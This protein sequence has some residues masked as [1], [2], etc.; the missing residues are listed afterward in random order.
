M[1]NET[2]RQLQLTQLEMLKEI[3]RVCEKHNITYFLTD[4]TL[5][6]AARHKGFIP[7]D[8]DLD[9]AMLRLDYDRFVSE[10]ISDIDRRYFLQ[11]WRTDS[12]YALPYAKLLKN[13]TKCVEA[14]TE[15]TGVHDGIFIDIFPID[16][17][18]SADRMKGKIKK[19]LFWNKVL[20]MKCKYKVWNATNARNGKWKYIPFAVLSGFMSKKFIV[21]KIESII[22][23]WNIN[24]AQTGLCYESCGYN[25]LNWIMNKNYVR[26]I[27]QIYFEDDLFSAPIDFQKYL[28]DVYGDYMKLPPVEDR[29]NQHNILELKF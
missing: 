12:N 6:G 22:N 8:D 11:T 20:L 3:K 25:F 27:T 5:L 16:F 21:E 23:D 9:I 19:Y 26:D 15:G 14:V 7:W 17:C 4:G 10:A 13:G 2:L 18:D 29:E 28:T 1:D 24:Y